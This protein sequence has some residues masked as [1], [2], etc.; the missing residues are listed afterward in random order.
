MPYHPC[1]ASNMAAYNKE[2]SA[3][4]TRCE[5]GPDRE[6]R[7]VGAAALTDICSSESRIFFCGSATP[8]NGT[9]NR[10]RQFSLSAQVLFCT[11]FDLELIHE[12]NN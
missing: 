8:T 3:G 4:P 7:Q 1:T 5:R 6:I 10:L 11:V 12:L 9:A 2:Q